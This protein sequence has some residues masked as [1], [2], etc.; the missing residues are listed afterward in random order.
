MR[1]RVHAGLVYAAALMVLAAFLAPIGWMLLMSL[2]TRA[3]IYAW[4]PLFFGFTP[5][6]DNYRALFAAGSSFGHYL[7][8]S[9][10]VA[11]AATVLALLVGL[12]AAYALVGQRLRWGGTMRSGVLLFRMLPPV[13]LLL[14]YYLMF[15]AAGLLGD[16]SAIAIAHFTFCI[17]ITV[18][19]MRAS[20]AAVPG[21]IEEAGRIDGATVWQIFRLLALPMVKA[22]GG[23]LRHLRRPHVVE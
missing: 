8:N 19:M 1:R 6:L 18:W 22:G 17:A 20:F 9:V 12:P 10:I 21:E 16:L 14:P 7:L 3:Q 4:P 15:R 11:M 13:A 5:T 2:K 23:G